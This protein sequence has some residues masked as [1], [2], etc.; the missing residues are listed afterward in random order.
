[1]EGH[2]TT[3]IGRLYPPTTGEVSFEGPEGLR[4]SVSVIFQPVADGVT[5]PW[6]HFATP[7]G[8]VPAGL[9]ALALKLI[10]L[11]ILRQDRRI[12]AIQRDARRDDEAAYAEGPLDL[13]GPTIWR[14]ANSKIEPER[15]YETIL[16]L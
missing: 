16:R 10:H 12:L 13:L 14:L 15:T 4:L 3:S 8:L 6:A 9:K 2:R 11:P 5:R 1:M 7:R